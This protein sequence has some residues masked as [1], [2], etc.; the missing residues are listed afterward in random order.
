MG[1]REGQRQQQDQCKAARASLR[2]E[3]AGMEEGGVGV[4]VSHPFAM[5]LRKDGARSFSKDLKVAG[6]M[7]ESHWAPRIRVATLPGDNMTGWPG[8]RSAARAAGLRY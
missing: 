1:G 7:P 6:R 5:K 4:V 3:G 8:R 2:E